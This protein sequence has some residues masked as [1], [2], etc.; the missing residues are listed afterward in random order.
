MIA[1]VLLITALLVGGLVLYR[2][3]RHP[4]R[5]SRISADS[6]FEAAPVGLFQIAEDGRLT[7]W[8]AAF[9]RL[10]EADAAE[11]LGA[12]DLGA[13]L[14]AEPA[15]ARWQR[16]LAG[17]LPPSEL[18]GS[19]RTLQGR[20]AEVT[21]ML[22]A[23]PAD[24]RPAT[25][26]VRPAGEMVRTLRGVEQQLTFLRDAIC[27]APV[28]L[29]TLDGNGRVG[30][31][32]NP[33]V[34]AI[35]GWSAAEL[36]GGA[37]PLLPADARG[38]GVRRPDGQEWESEAVR[39][40]RRDGR[41]VDLSIATA[42]IPGASG[43]VIAVV[44][45]VTDRVQRD[46]ERRRLDEVVRA[47]PDLV[48]MTDVDGVIFYRNP[49][50]RKRLRPARANGRGV[51]EVE[52]L[53][54]PML[55]GPEWEP[56]WRQAVIPLV[57][58]GESWT[59]DVSLGDPAFPASVVIVG[60]RS[61]DGRLG[62]L[63]LLA[64]DTSAQRSVEDQLRQAQKLEAVG[65][66][67]SGIAHDFNNLLTVVQSNVELLRE[68]EHGPDDRVRLQDIEAAAR[69]G[70]DLVRRLMVFSRDEKL[71]VRAYRLSELEDSIRTLRRLVPETVVVE[72]RC[73]DPDLTISA[74]AGAIEQ[75]LL[76]LTTNARDAMPDGGTLTIRVSARRRAGGEDWVEVAV[77]DTGHG[78]TPE[79]AARAFEPFYTTKPTG[80]GTGLGLAMCYGLVRQLEGEIELESAPGAGT[81][82][83]L[84]F[85]RLRTAAAAVVTDVEPDVMGA[86]QG[87]LILVAEDQAAIR[88]VIELSL[89][90]LGYEVLLAAD[91]AEALKLFRT[92][93]ADVDLVITDMVMPNLGGPGLFARVRE[94]GS[95]VPFLFVSG[96][97]ERETRDDAALHDSV[98]VLSKPWTRAE[99]RAAVA[100]AISGAAPTGPGPVP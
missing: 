59:G 52:S 47:T 41:P 53:W 30:E 72:W 93:A 61:R 9:S 23:G 16:W 7:A 99:L 14:T 68:G 92:H 64:R 70:R 97:T 71:A 50:A 2:I 32:W 87:G 66:L 51:T 77:S 44:Q 49:A 67:S 38:V 1:A 36:R 6:A 12:V 8:N 40:W 79:V 10:I 84:R 81:T 86:G 45:D 27:A 80:K 88:R 22:G 46:L 15:R 21:F 29:A 56:H 17:Q 42:P 19:L 57:M 95:A 13:L 76:N 43:Q 85:R 83:R 60:H 96:Y 34:E 55:L 89:A 28:G 26:A 11:A 54:A 31:V 18:R 78:M 58:A 3:G 63:S 39:R 25:A 65:Q 48:L 75:I 35:L 90:R 69:R 5:A 100:S 62:F 4:G 20:T 33:A 91:G 82:F 24:G 98:P 37:I 73:E 74:D 94:A